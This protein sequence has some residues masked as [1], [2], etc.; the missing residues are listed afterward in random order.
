[1]FKKHIMERHPNIDPDAALE[2]AMGAGRRSRS[3]PQYSSPLQWD[4]L[5]TPEPD[6]RSR[7]E[8]HLLTPLLQ[9]A[10]FSPISPPLMSESPV[11]DDPRPEAAELTIK[12]NANVTV[13][14]QDDFGCLI[15]VLPVRPQET[16]SN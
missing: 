6:R 12:I 16:V 15:L 3:V 9:V 7:A 4:V 11:N 1:V 5:P 10:K 8:P 14:K 13:T 2:E